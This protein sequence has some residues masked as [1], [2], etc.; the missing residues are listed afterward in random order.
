[1]L[2]SQS[3]DLF[4]MLLRNEFIFPAKEAG[5]I[6]WADRNKRFVVS[7][8]LVM[9][10]GKRQPA[11]PFLLSII[12]DL[13][14]EDFEGEEQTVY[15][16]TYRCIKNV[17]TDWGVPTSFGQEVSTRLCTRGKYTPN[18]MTSLWIPSSIESRSRKI[19]SLQPLSRSFNTCMRLTL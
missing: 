7:P 12:G 4:L 8:P 1:M 5:A 11:V 13:S 18:D 9:H 14:H 16:G 10:S 15:Y 17:S 6:K 2:R 3:R 19:S